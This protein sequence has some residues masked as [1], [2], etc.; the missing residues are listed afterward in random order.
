M[1]TC[2][3]QFKVKSKAEYPFLMHR[4]CIKIKHLPLSS[5]VN[6]PSVEFLHSLTAFCHLPISLVLFTHSL[7][8]AYE[9]TPV[10]L[11]YTTN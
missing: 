8:D 9:I 5:T 1:L 3:L 6:L 10:R 11:N 4:L 7:M 2:H